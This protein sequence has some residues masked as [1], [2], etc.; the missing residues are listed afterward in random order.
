MEQRAVVRLLALKDLKA[1]EIPMDVTSVYHDEAFQ[2]SAVKK[3]QA[4]F[5]QEGTEL[6]DDERSG[7]PADFDLARVIAELIRESPFFM[8]YTLQTSQGLERDMSLNPSREPWA[9]TS[10]FSMGAKLAHPEQIM[11]AA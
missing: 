5:L 6:E 1:K 11:K 9:Q 7:R 8:Q 10:S 4:R 2:I 3:W